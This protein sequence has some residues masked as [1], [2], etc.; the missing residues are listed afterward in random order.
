MNKWYT[1]TLLK[2]KI[3]AKEKQLLPSR[4]VSRNQRYL[5]AIGTTGVKSLREKKNGCSR[6]FREA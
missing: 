1:G 6:G 2:K 4:S 3:N 5:N